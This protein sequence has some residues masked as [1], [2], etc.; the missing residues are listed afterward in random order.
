[1]TKLYI[2]NTTVQDRK[3]PY[4]VVG[5]DGQWTLDIPRGAQVPMP[6]D[7]SSEQ[8]AGIVAQQE[9]YGMVAAT[10]VGQARSHISALYA[11]GKPVTESQMRLA[12]ERNLQ[13]MGEEGLRLRKMASVG[14]S[15][16]MSD[17]APDNYLGARVEV[18]EKSSE[19]SVNEMHRHRRDGDYSDRAPA[20]IFQPEAAATRGRARRSRRAN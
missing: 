9:H 19:P 3:M 5:L 1:M 8:I 4:R 17:Q 6:M 20:D 12:L 11:V 10:N 18:V 7:M 13:L 15:S 16:V 2:A 14:I